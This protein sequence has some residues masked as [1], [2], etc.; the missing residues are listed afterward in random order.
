M[1]LAHDIWNDERD[2]AAEWRSMPKNLKPSN[3]LLPGARFTIAD[4]STL[5]LTELADRAKLKPPDACAHLR[6]WHAT[7]SARPSAKA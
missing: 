2:W 6:R 1:S 3:L 5:V 7:V 4:I